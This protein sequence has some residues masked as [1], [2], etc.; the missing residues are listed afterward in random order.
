MELEIAMPDF[1]SRATLLVPS[2]LIHVPCVKQ[3]TDFS[4]GAAA[5]LSLLRYWVPGAFE[6][7]HEDDLFE[8]LHTTPANGTEPEPIAAYLQDVVGLEAKYEHGDVTLAQLEGAVDAG[9]P[10]LVDL[11]AWRDGN[12]PWPEV[13]DAGHY[14]VLV[15]Y[16]AENLFFMDPSVLSPGPYAYVPKA[17][18]DERWHDLAGPS[19][20]RVWRMTVFVRGDDGEHWTPDGST[21]TTSATRMG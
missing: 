12:R 9:Q 5:T 10:P 16:D 19:D 18:L 1:G 8:P 13:W 2:N 21:P 7:A 11:Q 6:D 3:R 15:G 20:T 14:V 17:E 4:C